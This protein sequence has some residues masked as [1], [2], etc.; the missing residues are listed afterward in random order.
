MY[1]KHWS[2][3]LT[4]TTVNLKREVNILCGKNEDFLNVKH[5]GV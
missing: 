5:S 1:G 4:E 3:L 2:I